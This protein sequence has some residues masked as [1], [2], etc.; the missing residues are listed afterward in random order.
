MGPR[1][2]TGCCFGVN[3]PAPCGT[4]ALQDEALLVAALAAAAGQQRSA[5]GV[6][7][8]LADALVCL[9]RALEV[10][11]C[12][13]LLANLLALDCK[14]AVISR[15]RGGGGGRVRV[16]AVNKVQRKRDCRPIMLLQHHATGPRVGAACAY[17]FSGDGL[18]ASLAQ[19]LCDLGVESQVFLAANKDDGKALAEVKDFGNPLQGARTST[20]ATRASW[21]RRRVVKALYLFLDVVE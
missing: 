6:L 12:T 15:G 8:H 3:G 7:K 2:K 19:L 4:N 13:N 5:G 20:A 21:S 9:G 10:L 16:L 14:P 17:L 1:G 11:V 18:L